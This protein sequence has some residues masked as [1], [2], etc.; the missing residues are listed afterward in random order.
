MLAPIPWGKTHEFGRA[1]GS[2]SQSSYTGYRLVEG[3]E[4]FVSDTRFNPEV[5]PVD[6]TY[7]KPLGISDNGIALYA[8]PVH[9]VSQ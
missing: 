5:L 4:I 8:Q 1:V 9:K 3:R 2:R 7:W 6:G